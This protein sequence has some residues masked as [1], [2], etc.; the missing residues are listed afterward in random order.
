MSSDKQVAIIGAGPG[1]LVAARYLLLHGFDPV[2]F[3]QS[4]RLGGQ[5]NQGAPHSGVW[6]AMLT[7]TSRVTTQFSDLAWPSGTPMFLHN[8]AVLAYLEKYADLFGITPRIRLRHRVDSVTQDRDGYTVTYATPD[9]HSNTEHFPCVIVASGRYRAPKSPSIPGLETF[10][11]SGGVSHTFHFRGAEQF[12]GKRVV[13]AGCSISA[14]EIAPELVFGG[15]ARVISC[16]RRQRYVLQRIV[17]GMPIDVLA[18][19]RFGVLAAERLPLAQSKHMFKEFILRTSGPPERWGACKAHDDPSVAGITQ[20]QFYLP[21]IAEG[22]IISKPWIRFI[23]GQRVT[24][25]DGAPEEV[26]AIVMGTG[27]HLD[28]PF[29]S[30]AIS[31]QVGADGPALRLYRHTF[32]PQLPKL[33]FVGLYHQQGPYLPSLELQARWVAYTWAGLRP[34][35]DPAEMSREIATEPPSELVLPMNQ[36]CVAFAR[37]AGVEPDLDQWPH[38]QRALLFGP[39]TPVSFRLSGPD[40]LPDAPQRF[41]E[42]A[43]EFGVITSPR[44]TVDERLRFDL[45]NE[46]AEA[47]A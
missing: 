21:L 36:R 44:L 30:P 4:S 11:G 33:A 47:R 24:F 20:G 1:G 22:K 5:W 42:E 41:I 13:I 39:L 32:H 3:E 29:L 37:D 15:A 23:D 12:R 8:R 6:P 14:V 35:P 27:F 2:I 19:T 46:H 40:A 45:L 31:E 25:D 17:A 38:L 10:S 34:Q 18:F 7:N 16:F 26:D 43:A 9:G 28:L